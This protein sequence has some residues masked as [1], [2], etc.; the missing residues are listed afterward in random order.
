MSNTEPML[1]GVVLET[2]PTQSKQQAWRVK[3][4]SPDELKDRIFSVASYADDQPLEAIQAGILVTFHIGPLRCH[5]H[6]VRVL[7]DQSETDQSKTEL[8][9]TFEVIC[10][11]PFYWARVA[12]HTSL[13]AAQKAQAEYEKEFSQIPETQVVDFLVMGISGSKLEGMRDF[14][15][16][17]EGQYL[18]SKAIQLGL[19]AG[20]TIGQ[21]NERAFVQ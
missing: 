11:K 8:K 3:V 6:D 14:L 12:Q 18:L 10:S 16:S 5:A 2:D 13:A 20:I 15:Q 1:T 7:T 4:I 9:L 19:R 21:N 17:E